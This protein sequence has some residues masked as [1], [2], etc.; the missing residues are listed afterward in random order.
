M[1]EGKEK[2]TIY[3]MI[4]ILIK[5]VVLTDQVTDFALHAIFYQ[6]ALMLLR[7]NGSDRAPNTKDGVKTFLLDEGL[8]PCCCK[9]FELR[10]SPNQM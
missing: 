4:D 8:N 1:K 6:Y 10:T 7:V 5:T 2:F 3:A 9:H